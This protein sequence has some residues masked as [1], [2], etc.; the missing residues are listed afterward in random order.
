MVFHD[1]PRCGLATI[2]NHIDFL[3][4]LRGTQSVRSMRKA[5][6]SETDATIDKYH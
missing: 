5:Q 3:C 6:L 4:E 1:A 2:D